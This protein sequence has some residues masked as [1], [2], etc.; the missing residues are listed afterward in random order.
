MDCR[1]ISEI[2]MK[3]MDGPLADPEK[4]QLMNHIEGCPDCRQEYDEWQDL[5]QALNS[6]PEPMPS[7]GFE[8]RV[9]AAI[10]PHL[11]AAPQ[12][13]QQRIQTGRMLVW[14]GLLGLVSLLVLETATLLQNLAVDWL[15]ATEMYRALAVVYER[16]ILGGVLY[17]LMPQKEL[18]DGL[19]RFEPA[20][21][22]WLV[23]GTLNLMMFLV[24]IK[25][26]L[27]RLRSAGRGE[28]Q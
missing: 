26:S 18:V 1:T 16:I 10:D 6:L 17:F 27:D 3:Q 25:V 4:Q 11:Y 13:M 8:T 5:V 15:Q 21:Q 14:M 7:P 28:A 20:G 12:R 24:L 22:W 19:L 2:M 23:L 9:M